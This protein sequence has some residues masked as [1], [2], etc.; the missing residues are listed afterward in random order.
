[1]PSPSNADARA[2]LGRTETWPDR[3]LAIWGEPG[4]GKTHLLHLWA[5]RTTATWQDGPGLRSLPAAS[6]A[7]VIDDADR[8]PDEATLL[9]TLN[10]AATDGTSVLISG[11]DAPGRWPVTLRDLASRLRAMTAVEI[12]PPEDSLLRAL[13]VRL[14]AE[15]QIAVPA[16][17]QEWLLLQ[18]PRT[19]RALREF[20]AL[21]DRAQ[22]AAGRAVTRKLADTLLK[23]MANEEAN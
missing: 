14:L 5:A 22:F 19:S 9:H 21:L 6:G 10:R 8:A 1:M 11:R 4:C 17:V 7:L 15:R 2:W 23:Q 20:V 3:R 13:L 16:D 12:R 18:L